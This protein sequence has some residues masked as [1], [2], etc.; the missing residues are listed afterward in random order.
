MDMKDLLTGALLLILSLTRVD[1]QSLHNTSYLNQ[2]GERVLRFECTLPIDVTDTW[3]LFT[4]D[5]NLE[6]WIAPVAHIELKSGGYIVTNYDKDKK[7]SDPGSITLPILSFID[8]ELLVLKVILNDNFVESVRESDKN[9]Q[10]VI[11]FIKVDR[12][13][14]KIVSSMIGW[15]TG[16]D[17]DKTYTF[18]EKGNEWTYQEL[19]KNY[20]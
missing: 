11:Q 8:H 19:I 20:K 9:L 10:E 14:T 18:F 17:W 13:H 7:L 4:V 2:S 6:K 12:K 3:K 1:G 16:P 5:E 15:G